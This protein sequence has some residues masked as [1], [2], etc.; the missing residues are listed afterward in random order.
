MPAMVAIYRIAGLDGEATENRV[1]SLS[2]DDDDEKDPE[3]KYGI[4]KAF[5]EKFEADG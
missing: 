4:L 3:K 2:A 5:L 1:E